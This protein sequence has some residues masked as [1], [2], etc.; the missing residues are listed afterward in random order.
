M[1]LSD[2][3]VPGQKKELMMQ[4]RKEKQ[5]TTDGVQC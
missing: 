3:Y 4:E 5:K 2:D 1:I